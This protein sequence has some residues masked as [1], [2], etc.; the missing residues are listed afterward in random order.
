MPPSSAGMRPGA[1]AGASST[2][3][4]TR[5]S[6][7]SQRSGV[8]SLVLLAALA[9]RDFSFDYVARSTSR[10]LPLGYTL[11]AFWS[12]QE[13]S[14]LLWL[15][16]LTGAASA[17][18]ALN[19]RLVREVLPWT[20]PIVAGV[21]LFFAFLLVV[22]REP[23]RHP[24][25]AGRRRG[26]EPEPPEPVHDRPPAD[27][28]PRLRGPDDPVRLRHGGARLTPGGRA[29]DRRHAPLD[30]RGL[31]VPRLRHPARREVGLRGGRLGRLV[32]LGS[33]SRTPRSCPGSSPRRSSTR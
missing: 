1:G 12:G 24:G 11:A 25:R 9:G 3:P 29:L 5:S 23:V 28:L 10:E 2:R 20:V 15:L 8:A 13:G 33:R 17:A 26:D 32:R 31:D 27:A 30:A 18:V 4:R 16:V 6:P 19:R 22:S 14:L 21:A 7:R